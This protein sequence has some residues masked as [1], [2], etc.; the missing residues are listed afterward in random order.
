MLGK[1]DDLTYTPLD[2]NLL[3]TYNIDIHEIAPNAKLV[4]KHLSGKIKNAN[5]KLAKVFMEYFAER[6]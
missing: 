6:V 5:K 2:V 3:G 1:R 4:N